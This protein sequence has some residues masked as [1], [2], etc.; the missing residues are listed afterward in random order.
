MRAPDCHATAVRFDAPGEELH[1]RGLARSIAANDADAVAFVKA[2][3]DRA[4]HGSHAEVEMKR[5]RAK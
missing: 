4:E 3:G 5:F 2:Q 1:E